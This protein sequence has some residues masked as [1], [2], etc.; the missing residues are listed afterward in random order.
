MAIFTDDHTKRGRPARSS[1]TR[2][3]VGSRSK[4]KISR[5]FKSP[6]V[7]NECGG[8]FLSLLTAHGHTLRIL[9]GFI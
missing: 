8:S 6:A 3:F 4:G 5:R 1:V 9:E 2:K 7:N